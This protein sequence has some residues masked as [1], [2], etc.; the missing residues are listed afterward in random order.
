M[1]DYIDLLLHCELSQMYF[2]TDLILD[3]Y[4]GVGRDHTILICS[5]KNHLSPL[6]SRHPPT[7]NCS[8]IEASQL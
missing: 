6:T 4:E 2:T 1:R 8:R 5:I 3:M 7:S